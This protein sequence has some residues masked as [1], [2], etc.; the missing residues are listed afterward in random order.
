MSPFSA[1]SDFFVNLGA[2]A[3]SVIGSNLAV[4]QPPT[5]SL[6]E[7]FARP[8]APVVI[9][10]PAPAPSLASKLGIG[11]IEKNVIIIGV[12]GLAAFTVY[13]FINKK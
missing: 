6:A 10:N 11:F 2:K 3:G 5:K 13:S 9:H 8:A 1:L 12:F 4:G 7:V